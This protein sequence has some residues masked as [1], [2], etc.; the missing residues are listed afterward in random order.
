MDQMHFEA[1]VQTF[2]RLPSRRDLLRGLTSAGFGFG[3]L[4][5]SD[6]AEA[7]TTH[8]KK[9]G[10][11]KR[12]KKPQPQS[13]PQPEP[14]PPLVF[15]EYGCIEVGQPCR[16][17]SSLCCSGVSEGSAPTEGQP[18]QSHCVAHNAGFCSAEMDSCTVGGNV[19][20][21]PNCFCM[22]TTGNA[23]FCGR[24]SSV[25]AADCRVCAKDTECQAEFGPGAACVVLDGDVC[26]VICPT[27]GQTACMIPCL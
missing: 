9:K 10:K 24:S 5:L 17:D 15:N 1:L 20:C 21:R 7:K 8:K 3:V 27:T 13:Q 26:G 2:S 23:G 19:P 4:R 12:K 6:V 16:G 18:D 11:K 22:R 25:G 14:L